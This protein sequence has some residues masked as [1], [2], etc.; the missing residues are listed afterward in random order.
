[1]Y[2]LRSLPTRNKRVVECTVAD[3]AKYTQ[4]ATLRLLCGYTA[5]YSNVSIRYD[6]YWMS[7][8]TKITRSIIEIWPK[9]CLPNLVSVVGSVYHIPY[10]LHKI[11]LVSSTLKWT[12]TEN[13]LSISLGSSV[14][15][16]RYTS[17]VTMPHL[18]EA[19]NQLSL[20]LQWP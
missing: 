6:W 9:P 7:P 19:L 1:M 20:K 14:S 11:R 12:N 3:C 18:E 5:S 16:L 4:S 8:R 10:G 13:H 2:N 15:C 17:R